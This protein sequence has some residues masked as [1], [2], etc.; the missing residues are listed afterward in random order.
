MV[1]LSQ[2]SSL[3]EVIPPFEAFCQTAGPPRVPSAVV[4]LRA[5]SSAGGWE[6]FLMAVG[7]CS[8]SLPSPGGDHSI[9]EL[10]G[11]EGPPELPE[12]NPHAEGAPCSRQWHDAALPTPRVLCPARGARAA[13]ACLVSAV[14][15]LSCPCVSCPQCTTGRWTRWCSGSLPT[16]SCLSTRR[17]SES[18]S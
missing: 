8:D 13:A 17:P 4:V 18:C 10:Q 16:W 6:V 5:L 15:M 2:L 1:H 7:Q 9:T 11:L 3:P 12:S 14:I